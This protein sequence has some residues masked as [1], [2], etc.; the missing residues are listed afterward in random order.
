MRRPVRIISRPKAQSGLDIRMNPG[1]GFNANQL[2]WPVMAGEFSQKD[3][4]TRGTI[5]A[6]DWDN[7]N[8]EAENGETVVTDLNHDGI[9]EHY[10]IG[11]ERH[12]NGGTPLN[13]PENSFIFSR[14]RSMK[15]KDEDILKMFGKSPKRS[16]YTPADLAKTYDINKYRRVLADP[17]SDDLERE[18]AEMMIANYNLKLG[19]LALAQESLKGFPQGIPAISMPYLENMGMNP[20]EFIQTQGQQEQPAPD[21]MAKYGKEIKR[22]LPKAQHGFGSNPRVGQTVGEWENKNGIISERRNNSEYDYIWN[23]TDFVPPQSSNIGASQGSGFPR[24]IFGNRKQPVGFRVNN[25]T[26]MI[27]VVNSRGDVIGIATPPQGYPG[28]GAT[29]QTTSALSPTAKSSTITKVKKQNIPEDAIVID[30]KGKTQEEIAAERSKVMKANPGKPIYTKDKDGKYYKVTPSSAQMDSK[31]RMQILNQSFRDP[32]VA[33]ALKEKMIKA[34][35]KDINYG[36]ATRAKKKEYIEQIKNM[37]AQQIV[38]EFLD[39]NNR[40]LVLK[41]TLPAGALACFDNNTGKRKTS[42]ECQDIPYES[43]DQIFDEKGVSLKDKDKAFQQMTYIAYNDLIKGKNDYEDEELK[44][45]LAPFEIEQLGVGDEQI[46]GKRKGSVSQADNVYTNTTSGEIAGIK[47]PEEYQEEM[48]DE[49]EEEIGTKDK[50]ALKA[51]RQNLPASWGLQDIINVAGAAGIL[52]G[53]KKYMPWQAT[54]QTFLSEGVF[55]DPNRE[56]AANAESANI[57]A[58]NLAAFQGPQALSARTSQIQGQAARNA[59]DILGRY[60]N[61]NVG[62]ANQLAAQRAQI[63]NQAS[64][65]R[66]ALATTL[67]DKNTIANQQFDNAK[68]MARQNLRQGYIDALTNKWNTFNLNQLFPQYQIH[69]EIGGGIFFGD[70]KPVTPDSSTDNTAFKRFKEY[71]QALPGD[72]D[73]ATIWNIAKADSGQG[74]NP[75]DEDMAYLQAVQASRGNI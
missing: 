63:L 56:L 13:L 41:D 53:V 29:T 11:G 48:V 16:G 75:Y 20:E 28:L 72:I 47:T 10:K 9:T 36:Q 69:T 42:K 59:A 31:K 33:E 43:L 8:L 17:D 58:Q 62:I 39:F 2:S 30:K 21:N 6:T 64:Q 12:Y 70:G 27:E 18:T 61:L 49:V 35:E 54:P 4:E 5:E 38:D 25:N 32:K 55:Y 45:K 57:M 50:E 26:G 40:N 60:S 22:N 37:D 44:T 66:A 7:A 3:V 19:K 65:Q 73:D 71:R 74:S 67:Y 68:N 14:D 15:I 52:A 46:A 24:K 1:M 23:G 34:A 51:Y